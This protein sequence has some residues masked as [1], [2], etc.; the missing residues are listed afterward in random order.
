MLEEILSGEN[1]A[2]SEKIEIFFKTGKNIEMGMGTCYIL[3]FET[4]TR[5]AKRISV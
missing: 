4:L 1:L 5:D 3:V 2:I